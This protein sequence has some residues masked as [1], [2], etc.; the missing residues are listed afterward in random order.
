MAHLGRNRAFSSSEPNSWIGSDPSSW[1]IRISATDADALASSST[2]IWSIIVPVPVPPNSSA[3]GSAR[4]SFSASSS[5]MSH[6][7]S[8]LASISA[9]RGVTRS[10]AIWRT[11]SRKSLCSCGI[12]IGV[13]HVVL[14]G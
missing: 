4:M 1:T 14:M 13:G 10:T 9:A 8:S 2:A 11:R 5:R 12:V 6:G 3:K 7:Y